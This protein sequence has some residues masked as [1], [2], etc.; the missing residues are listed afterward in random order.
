MRHIYTIGGFTPVPTQPCLS[1]G[2]AENQIYVHSGYLGLMSVSNELCTVVLSWT[3]MISQAFLLDT[4][5]LMLTFVKFICNQASS[6]H[7]TMQCL[8]NVGFIRHGGFQQLNSSMTWERLSPMH[9]QTFH[10]QLPHQCH[11]LPLTMM[12]LLY[13]SPARPLHQPL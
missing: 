13:P 3:V 8:R 9:T 4:L 2:T 11:R 12:E 6:S 5:Q 1:F 10:T 7:A